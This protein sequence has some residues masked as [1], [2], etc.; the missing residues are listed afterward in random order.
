[1]SIV[2][3]FKEFALKGNVIDLAIGVIIGAAF[4]KI[5]TSAVDDII[6]PV[7]GIIDAAR[8]SDSRK[9]LPR[10]A[11]GSS[12]HAGRRSGTHTSNATH[13]AAPM[14][15]KVSEISLKRTLMTTLTTIAVIR[16][17]A[18]MNTRVQSMT[19]PTGAS[20]AIG[21]R[22]CGQS[23]IVGVSASAGFLVILFT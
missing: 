18:T 5:V 6:M 12:L 20:R 4:G 13:T 21:D 10:M 16:I 9:M 8:T 11:P 19:T 14:N 17:S 22:H 2:K 1:M 23:F 7:V 15:G 3:E